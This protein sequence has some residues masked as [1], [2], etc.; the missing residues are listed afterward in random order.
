VSFEGVAEVAL[1]EETQIL[2]Q[3]RDRHRRKGEAIASVSFA[4]P[5]PSPMLGRSRLK[6]EAAS[7]HSTSLPDR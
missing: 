4:R 1:I 6:R 2:G 7:P 5:Q 3:I